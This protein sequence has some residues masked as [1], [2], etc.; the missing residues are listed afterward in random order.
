V[1]SAVV[2]DESSG[3]HCDLLNLGKS[4]TLDQRVIDG[5][6]TFATF[7]KFSHLL[8]AEKMR[9]QQ[10]KQEVALNAVRAYVDVLQKTKML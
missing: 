2:V 9:F 10:S 6:G 8:K 7:S 4:L 3:S 5:G 1:C